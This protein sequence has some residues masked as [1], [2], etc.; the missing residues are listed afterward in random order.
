MSA[1]S[2]SLFVLALSAWIP[3]SA[4]ISRAPLTSSC[5]PRPAAG[6]VPQ[7]YLFYHSLVSSHAGLPGN[8]VPSRPC[9]RTKVIRT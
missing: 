9:S 2:K 3:A 1:L 8:A 7:D 4:A 5:D 6:T